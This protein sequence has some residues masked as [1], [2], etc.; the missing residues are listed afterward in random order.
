M[1]RIVLLEF[2][3]NGKAE[4]FV[5]SVDRYSSVMTRDPE[6]EE[7]NFVE[8]NVAAVV[9]KPTKW[10]T[11]NLPNETKYQ[12]RR[13]N[14]RRESSWLRGTTFG[15][16]LCVHCGKPSKAIVT[17]WVTNMLAGANDLLPKIIGS[18]TP[19]SPRERWQDEGGVPN[20][21]ANL[22]APMPFAATTG[23]TRKKRAERPR[24]TS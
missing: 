17:H 12:R 18:G 14:A 4:E 9:A 11:C 16:W 20:P 8:A 23:R 13:R 22:N 21:H 2:S 5:R 24:R 10:C 3:D 15:W 1:S 7:E 6:T 19:R